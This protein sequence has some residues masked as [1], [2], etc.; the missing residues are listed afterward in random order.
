[1]PSEVATPNWN[2]L[3]I[4]LLTVFEPAPWPQRLQRLQALSRLGEQLDTEWSQP[5]V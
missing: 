5:V 1:M 4:M 3:N 2:W